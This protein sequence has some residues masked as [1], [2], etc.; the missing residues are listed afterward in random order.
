MDR[1]DPTQLGFDIDGVAAD[2]LEAFLRILER[3]Y[4]MSGYR[5]EDLTE[6]MIEKCWNIPQ[7][8][9]SKV[10]LQIIDDPIGCGLKLMPGAGEVLQELGEEHTL[11]FITARP[12]GH[13][14][15]VWLHHHLDL[16]A[17]RIVVE[18]T[19]C[20]DS[21]LQLLKKH[22][23]SYF[24][25]DRAETCVGLAQAGINSIVYHSPWNEGKHELPVV[26][27]WA[28]IRELV[29]LQDG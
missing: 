6:H 18:Y 12:Q 3:D 17:D 20:H 28:E 26:R 5:L 16:P 27:D 4:G 24:I 10:I 29:G 21:K 7:T 25:D 11:T 19:N 22:D 9:V 15:Y 14:A 13:S 2:I 23:I 8:L 1:V